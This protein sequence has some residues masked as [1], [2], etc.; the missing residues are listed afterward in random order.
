[1]GLHSGK[2]HSTDLHGCSETT[3]NP[4]LG[5][6]WQ[7]W[8]T[9]PNRPTGAPHTWQVSQNLFEDMTSFILSFEPLQKIYMYLRFILRPMGSL[10]CPHTHWEQHKSITWRTRGHPLV[11]HILRNLFLNMALQD[12]IEPLEGLTTCKYYYLAPC[13]AY[14]YT[15]EL[16]WWAC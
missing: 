1:M 13:E 5:R 10:V 12:I 6:W 14:F 11:H 15:C 4:L 3:S 7:D 9:M 16:V 8:Y 2:Q